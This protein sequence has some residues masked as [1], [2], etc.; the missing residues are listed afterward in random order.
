MM[1]NE[2]QRKI[3]LWDTPLSS[4]SGRFSV[5][6]KLP[7]LRWKERASQSPLDENKNLMYRHSYF[8]HRS[9]QR[10]GL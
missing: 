5:S 1:G 4:S 2:M 3:C 8:L 6:S 7:E 10:K 9:T